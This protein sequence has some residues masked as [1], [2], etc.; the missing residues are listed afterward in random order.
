MRSHDIEIEP[1][2][3]TIHASRMKESHEEAGLAS[4]VRPRQPSGP[5]QAPLVARAVDGVPTTLDTGSILHLQRTAGNSVV[6]DLLAGQG[7]ESPVKDFL[8]SSPGQ[9]L[10]GSVRSSMEGALGADLS[11]VKV[12]RGGD[13]AASA[14][15]VQARAYTVGSDV[16]LGSDVDPTSPQGRKTLA[17]ELT[18]VVQQRSGPVDGTPAPGGIRLSAPGDR[19]EQAAESTAQAVMAGGVAPGTAS[20]G[21]PTGATAQREAARSAE[22]EQMEEEE[23]QASFLQR[24]EADEQEEE[25]EGA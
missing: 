20:G 25:S 14:A 23:V 1:T 19:F 22:D 2:G 18:H 4:D 10:D 12:H 3:P 7:E 16:V 24:Q 21:S 17:H 13:A 11:D 6:A 5:A 9:T 8:S 15:S